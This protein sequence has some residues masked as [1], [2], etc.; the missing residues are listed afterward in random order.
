M[1]ATQP[2]KIST[3]PRPVPQV[4]NITPTMAEQWL[5]TMVANRPISDKNVIEFATAMAENRWSLNG[6]TIK[7]DGDGHLFD[8]QNRLQACILSEVAFR[9]YVVRGIEDPN[10]MATVDTGKSRT[11]SDVFAIAGWQNNQIAAG[12]ALVIYAYEQKR[13]NWSGISARYGKGNDAIAAKLKRGATLSTVSRDV[14]HRYAMSIEEGLKQ[15][16]RFA[17]SSKA[18]RTMPTAS[19]A[20]LYYIFRQ[21]DVLAAEKFFSDLGEGL[22]MIKGD[23]VYVLREKLLSAKAQKAQKITK[24]AVLGLAIKAWNKRRADETVKVLGIQSGED[25]PRA[26]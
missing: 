5:K 7:F 25:F 18:S 22:G 1:A 2:S 13:L 23:P 3:L 24:W 6:E 10:A 14:L 19:A 21:K 16:V 20:A 9:S 12:A 11:A 17:N 15:A 26:R 4:V 8:G